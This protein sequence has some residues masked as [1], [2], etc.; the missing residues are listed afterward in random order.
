MNFFKKYSKLTRLALFG[1]GL[2][3]FLL[4]YLLNLTAW[5]TLI[6]QHPR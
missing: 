4:F 2:G 6:Q 5:Y 3:S 1:A